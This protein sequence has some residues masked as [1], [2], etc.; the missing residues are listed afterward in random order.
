MYLVMPRTKLSAKE[1]GG[2]I[3]RNYKGGNVG[4]MVV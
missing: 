2:K 3:V 1:V 4:C